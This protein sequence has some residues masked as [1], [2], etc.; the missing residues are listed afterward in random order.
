M[1]AAV[2]APRLPWL[3]L[4]PLFDHVNTPRP[5]VFVRGGFRQLVDIVKRLALGRPVGKPLE[6][7]VHERVLAP[8]EVVEPSSISRVQ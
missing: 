2:P 4:K 7:S 6:R 3:T 5:T 1:F 8:S